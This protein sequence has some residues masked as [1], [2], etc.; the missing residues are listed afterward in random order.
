MDTQIIPKRDGLVHNFFLVRK[1]NGRTLPTSRTEQSDIP[2]TGSISRVAAAI[3]VNVD[4]KTSW[5]G[6]TR[7][8]EL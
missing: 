2:F 4:G 3:Y 6:D 5:K 1:L 8:N 7:K